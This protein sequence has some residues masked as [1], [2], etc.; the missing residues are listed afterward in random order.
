MNSNYKVA[1]VGGGIFGAA[2]AIEIATLNV[3][4]TIFERE[5]DLLQAASGINQYRL[6]RGYHYPRSTE[7]A[8]SVSYTHLTLPTNREV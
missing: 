2:A 7:T 4:V 5:H 3:D 6:H 1:V 8:L